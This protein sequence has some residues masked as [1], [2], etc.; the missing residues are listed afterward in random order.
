M[1][2][3]YV[4][5]NFHFR[6]DD[7][8]FEVCMHALRYL[9]R[10]EAEFKLFYFLQK[11]QRGQCY[12]PMYN[13]KL[14]PSRTVR[15]FLIHNY[16]NPDYINKDITVNYRNKQLVCHQANWNPSAS[17]LK[18]DCKRTKNLNIT[19]LCNIW[20][21]CWKVPTEFISSSVKIRRHQAFRIENSS[22]TSCLTF[23]W[24]PN[25]MVA[26]SFISN[27]PV[28]LLNRLLN[29]FHKIHWVSDPLGERS[30]GWAILWVALSDRNL[31]AL[32]QSETRL[33]PSKWKLT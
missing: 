5:I 23:S 12:L 8:S 11:Q 25:W 9:P 14:C 17:E 3:S 30:S 24:S 32:D 10:I 31:E 22:T 18:T 7:D 4:S 33:E 15:E 29:N 1:G 19:D 20:K 13:L 27:I 2:F 26:F 6:A 28:L 16:F 21:V